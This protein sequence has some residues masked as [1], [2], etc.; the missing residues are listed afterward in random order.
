[1]HESKASAIEIT[2]DQYYRY[3]FSR[4]QLMLTDEMQ[5]TIRNATIAV[6]GLGGIGCMAAEMMVRMGIG[7]FKLADID[8]FELSNL[9][10]QLFSD[11]YNCIGNNCSKQKALIASERLKRINPFCCVDIIE[12]GINHLNVENFCRNCDIIIAQPDKEGIKV[13]LHRMAKK[14]SIP[15]VTAARANC[16]DNRWTLAARV[17]DYRRNPDLK[18]FEE[19]HHPELLR[20]SLEELT[21]KVLG[22]YHRKDYAKV[23][24]RWRQIIENK[25]VSDFGLPD[26]VNA[27]QVMHSCPDDFH[28]AH[29]LAPI[30]N[31]AGAL[32]SIEVL[33][34]L[35]DQQTW[36]YAIDFWT[37]K[38]FN[39]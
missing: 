28:K 25:Q 35:I 4:S 7:K 19:T 8:C 12:T 15:I 13:L 31:I 2:E 33:K 18:T 32:A 34:L 17:W 14:H 5:R 24:S 1:M 36:P 22:E 10:R 11:Y 37:G 20:Y 26:L 6:V 30:A 38:S 23:R 16:S 29:I 9:N 39:V 27:R 21:P 3:L